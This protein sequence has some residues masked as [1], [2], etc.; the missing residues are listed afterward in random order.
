MF[1]QN[2]FCMIVLE[3]SVT[4]QPPHLIVELED[5]QHVHARSNLPLTCHPNEHTVKRTIWTKIKNAECSGRGVVSKVYIVTISPSGF[6]N[7]LPFL[8]NL[9]LLFHDC[10]QSAA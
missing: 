3:C 2:M 8:H 5:N 1:G 10:N 9:T 6:R 7:P 4:V